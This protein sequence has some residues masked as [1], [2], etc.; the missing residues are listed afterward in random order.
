M[1]MSARVAFPILITFLGAATAFAQPPK[2]GPGGEEH[3][4]PG[5]RMEMFAA[6]KDKKA[7]D[8][9]EVA[10][11]E[12]KATGKCAV[13]PDG[14]LICHVPPPPELLKACEGKKEGDACS[15]SMPERKIDGNCRKGRFDDKLVC[16][17]D[18]REGG[19]GPGGKQ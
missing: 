17:P 8:S 19:G 1:T 4:G 3:H 14:K 2:G 10:F 15:A 18:R 9:C 11:G 6:C 12:H 13:V 16:R 5:P 7:G